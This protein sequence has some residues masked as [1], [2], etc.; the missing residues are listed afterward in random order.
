MNNIDYDAIGQRVE[1]RLVRERNKNLIGL[2]VAN[3]VL[4]VVFSVLVWVILPLTNFSFSYEQMSSA[5]LATL[6]LLSTGWL[7]GLILHGATALTAS[8]ALNKHLR[9]R[10]TAQEIQR[11]LQHI[12]RELAK[13][14][15]SGKP[16]R[17]YDRLMLGEDGEL[18]EITTDNWDEQ[19][20][21]ERTR[22]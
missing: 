19:P 16:K 15:A 4:F 3:L 7:T 17:S 1:S 13:E 5:T 6:I 12:S 8:G 22:R 21:S 2:F 18:L 14:Q 20:E 9:E 10:L 11:E